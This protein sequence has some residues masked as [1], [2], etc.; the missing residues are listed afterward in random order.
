MRY[1]RTGE[2]TIGLDSEG[3]GVITGGLIRTAES[4]R[5]IEISENQ[6]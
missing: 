6:N 5:R 3:A 1:W 2:E 4:G